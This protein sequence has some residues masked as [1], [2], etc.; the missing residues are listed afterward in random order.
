MALIA[1]FSSRI[2]GS[3]T[4]LGVK[5]LVNETGVALAENILGVI[6]IGV[7]IAFDFASA[8][9]FAAHGTY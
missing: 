9:G 4:C 8:V 6:T 7:D 5:A 3:C 2:I 1:T